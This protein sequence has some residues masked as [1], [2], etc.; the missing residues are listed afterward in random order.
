M[1][2]RDIITLLGGAVAWP[3]RAQQS[4]MPV[5]GFLGNGS[6]ESDAFRVAAIR[7]GLKESG[8]VE[9]RDIAFEYRWAEDHND[10]LPA[11][12]ADLV[13][14]EVAVIVLFSNVAVL[15]AKSA[16]ATIPIIFAIGGDPIKLGLVAS[17]NRPGGNI[18][19]V[20]FLLDTLVAKQFEVLHETIPKTA[21]IGFLVSPTNPYAESDMNN[22]LAAAELV[23]QK[24]IIVKA[25]TDS[26]LEAAFTTLVQ[27]GAGALVVCADPFFTNRQDKLIESAARQKIPAIYYIREFAAAGGLMSYGT[28]ITD[29]GRLVGLY[30]GRILKGEKP[31]ELPVQQSVKVELIVNLKTAKALGLT[32]PSHIVAR[33]DEVIE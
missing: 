25:H 12:A 17:L 32:V 24:I 7:Q 5:V 9:G 28:S 29:A 21:L 14:H 6:R 20:S 27:Q 19:G 18:T 15:A 22:V 23:G 2:R 16:T 26:E 31:A 33:A 3:A 11:L 8:Y 10:R 13:R 4:K 1:R 30:A